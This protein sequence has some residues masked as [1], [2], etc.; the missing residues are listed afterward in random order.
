MGSYSA[1]NAHMLLITGTT[2]VALFVAARHGRT[3]DPPVIIPPAYVYAVARLQLRVLAGVTVYQTGVFIV[4]RD[5]A[6][7]RQV[8]FPKFKRENSTSISHLKLVGRLCRVHTVLNFLFDCRRSRQRT[9]TS[10]YR[11][12]VG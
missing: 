5:T 12:Y 2:C 4:R 11:A 8:R 3:V 9:A 10:V 6:S 7:G 1:K